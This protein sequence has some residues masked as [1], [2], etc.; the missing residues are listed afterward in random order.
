[1]LTKDWRRFFSFRDLAQIGFNQINALS[2]LFLC[3][4]VFDAG[5]R[6]GRADSCR[7]PR[8]GAQAPPLATCY[9]SNRI[10]WRNDGAMARDY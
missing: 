8:S 4:F 9:T 7:S 10:P 1:M 6:P 3:V 5:R 2:T